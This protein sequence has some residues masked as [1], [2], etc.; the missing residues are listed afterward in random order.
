MRVL[1]PFGERPDFAYQKTSE[2]FR[3]FG[4]L[5]GR[6]WLAAR[7][8]GFPPPRITQPRSP[9][10]GERKRQSPEGGAPLEKPRG[11]M[12]KPQRDRQPELMDDPSLAE[13][14]HRSA[15]K[16]LGHVNSLSRTQAILWRTVRSI[17][18]RRGQE[19]LKILDIASGGG[20]LAIR[21]AQRFQRSGISV[22]FEGCDI[23]DSSRPSRNMVPR[24]LH[25]ACDPAA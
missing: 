1:L 10:S 19:P 12:W 17:S 21:L 9:R 18:P 8:K 4:S 14:A 5:A 25:R 11:L 6:F 2:V 23:S 3:D 16:G 7:L 20:D 24:P 22:E 13:S 15:L